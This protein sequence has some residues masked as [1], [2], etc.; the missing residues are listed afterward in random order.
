MDAAGGLPV[1]VRGR[2]KAV[3]EGNLSPKVS[4]RDE[5]SWLRPKATYDA[6]RKRRDKP[7]PVRRLPTLAAIAHNLDSNL[8]ISSYPLKRAQAGASALSVTT[9]VP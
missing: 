7:L 8:R 2:P 4:G 1:L 6:G 5:A 3:V 9:R